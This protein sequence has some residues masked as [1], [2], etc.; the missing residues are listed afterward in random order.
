[1]TYGVLLAMITCNP[2]KYWKMIPGLLS[3]IVFSLFREIV[4]ANKIIAVWQMDPARHWLYSGFVTLLGV[5]LFL[6]WRR[7]SKDLANA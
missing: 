5:L 6:F 7:L 2:I 1:M 3:L 4:F